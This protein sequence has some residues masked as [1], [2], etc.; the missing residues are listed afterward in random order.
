M[1]NVV[2]FSGEGAYAETDPQGP[3]TELYLKSTTAYVPILGRENSI[4]PSA[5]T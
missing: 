5:T 2:R 1:P 4:A 3:K